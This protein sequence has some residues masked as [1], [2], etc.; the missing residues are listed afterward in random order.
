MA[1][2]I[3]S[4]MDTLVDVMRVNDP[5][6]KQVTSWY[7][8]KAEELPDAIKPDDVPCVVSYVS[9]PQVQYSKG[10]PAKLFWVGQSEFH[11][12]TDVKPSNIPYILK[13]FEIIIRACAANMKLSNLV[14]LFLI[15]Q[16]EQG[17]IQFSTYK[18]AKGDDDHQ[19]IIVRWQVTQDVSGDLEVS[20]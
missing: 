9:D 11:L 20:A 1:N 5:R 14:T 6:G 3:E 8:F 2:W 13:F 16:N 18:N 17:A 10:G 15:V 19:G 7:V 4:W 12:T